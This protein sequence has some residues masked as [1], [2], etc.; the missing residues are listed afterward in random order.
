MPLM[1]GFEFC[2]KVKN[3]IKI[4]HIPLLMMTAKGMQIDKIK[5]IDHGADAYLVKPFN[6]EILK[7]HIKQLISSRQILFNK[8]FNVLNNDQLTNTTTLDKQFIT[9]ILNYINENISNSNL[10]VEH[11]AEELLLSRS[12]LYRKIKALT[13]DT[14][15][16][17]IRKVK[18][19]KAKNLIETTDLTVSEICY[20]VGFSSPSYFTKCFKN[21]FNILPKEMKSTIGEN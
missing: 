21:H 11:L 7:S 3:D 14:A 1:D 2:E 12:K 5:G 19:E 9:N 4:S 10:G 8:Y 18:L 15:T 13:G 6:M 17:F 20:Q 16:E